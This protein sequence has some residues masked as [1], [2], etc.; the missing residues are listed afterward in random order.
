MQVD[1]DQR[2]DDELAINTPAIGIY[3]Q[4]N[5][6]PDTL[7]GAILR[8]QRQGHDVFIVPGEVFGPELHAV[9][10]QLDVTVINKSETSRDGHSRGVLAPEAREAG[11]PGVIWQSDPGTRPRV[12][13]WQAPPLGG[14]RAMFRFY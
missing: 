11:Y 8:A 2:S 12:L 3:V 6:D 7:A 5:S 4:P 1:I 14:H 9:T 13:Q 10:A